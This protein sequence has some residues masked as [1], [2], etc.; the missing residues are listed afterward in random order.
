MSL[1]KFI[2]NYSANQIAEINQS[3]KID[4]PNK[5]KKRGPGR[6]KSIPS[7][8][9]MLVDNNNNSNNDN[10]E[11]SKK[12]TRIDWFGT[13]FILDILAAYKI[14]RSGYKTV[15]YLQTRFPSGEFGGRFDLLAKSTIDGWFD[16]IIIFCLNIKIN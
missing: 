10:E 3:I 8:N 4:P 13:P 15:Q 1:L 9:D 6:P 5:P 14:H 7:V 2:K 16:E 12:S 11:D